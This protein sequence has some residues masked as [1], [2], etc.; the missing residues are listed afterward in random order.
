MQNLN[1]S[2]F[3][4]HVA[5]F[6]H[7]VSGVQFALVPSALAAA[8]HQAVGTITIASSIRLT[9]ITIPPLI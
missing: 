6:H 3:E 4:Y 9:T 2:K 1:S 7:W 8:I 5:K